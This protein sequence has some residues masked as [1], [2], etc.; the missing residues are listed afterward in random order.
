MPGTLFVVATPIGNLEDIT[1]RA[2]RVL[3]EVAVIAAEDTRHTA[4]LLSHFGISTPTISFHAHNWKSRLPAIIDRLNAGQHVALV[5]DAGTP[6]LSD[7][8]LELVDAC[9][10]ASILV[11]ALPGASAALTAAVAS[12]FP[13]VPLTIYGFPPYRSKDRIGWLR[14]LSKIPGTVT[15]F[16]APHRI[17]TTLTE[18]ARV[19][20]K[21][22]IVLA[23]ELTK[24]NQQ[25]IRGSADAVIGL[26][27]MVRGE[28]TVVVG[29]IQK[30]I[31]HPVAVADAELLH[32]FGLMAKNC[33][34]SR[35]D[36]VATLARKFRKSSREVYTAVERAKKL[37]DNPNE[38]GE[39][40]I[41]S[42]RASVSN[43]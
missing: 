16:E 28:F 43:H 27:T 5:S 4:K 35:R 25:F 29:P 34:L 12:G 10:R 31:Q 32:E 24:A 13:L 21:R 14:E 2:L 6:G 15:F 7:P 23:R 8:G 33:A 40:T 30:T 9:I 3:K 38:T 18:M 17:Q 20:G 42:G 41:G 11:N 37:G 26:L 19:L 22:P 39:G 36:I 1:L